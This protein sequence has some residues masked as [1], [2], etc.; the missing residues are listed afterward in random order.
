MVLA[1]SSL[2]FVNAAPFLMSTV[3]SEQQNNAFALQTA[4]LAL[5][6]F[7]GSLF[8]GNFAA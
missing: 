2:Y 6:A 3:N 5:A 7:F 8:G 1:G 4:L